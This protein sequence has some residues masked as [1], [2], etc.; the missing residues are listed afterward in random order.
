MRVVV[1]EVVPDSPAEKGGILPGDVMVSYNTKPV[2]SLLQLREAI[3]EVT[4]GMVKIGIIRDGEE[5]TLE[6]PAGK[7]GVHI[8]EKAPEIELKPDA[9]VLEGIEPLGWQYGMSSSFHASLMR[10]LNYKGSDVDYV[11]LM[12][13]SGAAFRVHFHKDWCPSSP[14]P[15]CGF[16]CGSK[17]IEAV[18]YD[19]TFHSLKENGDN[20]EEMREMIKKSVDNKMPVIAI[21]LIQVPEWG[22][23]TGYQEN[24]QEFLCRTYYDNVDGYNLA[25]KFPWV[26]TVLGE[27]KEA[28]EDIENYKNSFK[29]GLELLKTPMY[30]D[31]YS[32]TAALE[33]WIGA[34]DKVN[35]EELDSAKFE[36]VVLANAWTYSRL[37][38]DREYASKYMDRIADEFGDLGN[39]IKKIAELY[40]EEVKV[41][42]KEEGITPYPW[43]IKEPQ[44]WTPKMRDRERVLLKEALKIEQEAAKLFQELVKNEKK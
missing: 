9:V 6:I 13:V 35:L 36:E 4:E 44:D 32:G 33:Y 37:I 34:L 15:T 28:S 8:S 29:I 38:E 41:L 12:G 17:A 11:Y 25:Q 16:D 1:V 10:I 43:M 22:I 3:G 21:D 42:K 5:I 30:D 31:Y 20:K 7:M 23:I 19:Y 27:K 14:D 2:H 39:Y 26:V 24:G 18:G 40:R